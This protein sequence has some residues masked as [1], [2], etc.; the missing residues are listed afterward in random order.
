MIW[1]YHHLRKHP[2]EPNLEV[3]HHFCGFYSLK[4]LLLNTWFLV[5]FGNGF[6]K[7]IHLGNVGTWCAKKNVPTF[8]SPQ[9]KTWHR[10]QPELSEAD[11]PGPF[12]LE[13]NR[14]AK[15]GSTIR[16]LLNGKINPKD[17]Q[18]LSLGDVGFLQF[19]RVVSGDYGKPCK[20]L[21][22]HPPIFMAMNGRWTEQPDSL[23][24][25]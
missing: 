5:H 15:P 6:S 3:A 20:R 18:V 21:G 10:C 2:H 24:G 13:K 25:T 22:S 7:H 16:T 12:S 17:W 8:P 9:I 23:G 4:L 19:F 11:F 1:G 14:D